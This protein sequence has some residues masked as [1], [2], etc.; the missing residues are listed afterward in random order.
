MY[1]ESRIHEKKRNKINDGT[2]YFLSVCLLEASLY[3]EPASY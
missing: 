3:L 2:F 1:N